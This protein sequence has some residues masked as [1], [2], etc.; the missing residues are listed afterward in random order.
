M[1]SLSNSL[2]TGFMGNV[3]RAMVH[4][5]ELSKN[6]LENKDKVHSYW[7]ARS[8]FS[9]FYPVSILVADRLTISSVPGGLYSSTIRGTCHGCWDLHGAPAVRLRPQPAIVG[10]SKCLRILG[11]RLGGICCSA[12]VARV[13]SQHFSVFLGLGLY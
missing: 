4:V 5:E 10:V 3:R 6:K 11:L 8:S 7:S 12:N 9:C 13:G 2:M 1:S